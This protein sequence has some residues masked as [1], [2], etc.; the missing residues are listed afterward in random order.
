[1]AHLTSKCPLFFFN[2]VIP[3]SHNTSKLIE[4]TSHDTHKLI[5][6]RKHTTEY[7]KRRHKHFTVPYRAFD[8][9]NHESPIRYLLSNTSDLNNIETE[10]GREILSRIKLNCRDTICS[11]FL[12]NS[13]EP[14]FKYCVRKTWNVSLERYGEPRQSLCVFMNGSNRYPMGLASYPGS[15]NTWVRG[16]FQKVTGLCTGGIYCDVA[17]RQNGYPGESI[18]S[19]AT[20]LVKSHLIDPRW[21]GVKYDSQSSFTYFKYREHVPVFSGGV[22]ILRN[23]FHAM[24]AEFKREAWENSSTHHTSSLGKEHFGKLI[25]S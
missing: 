22:F 2:T 16:L 3:T 23:P 15:G 8:D 10:K 20:F 18:R 9:S 7:K 21:E 25:V 4:Q 1:M 19:G 6:E 24:V 11:K 17:L 12:T 14:H 13:D 5:K